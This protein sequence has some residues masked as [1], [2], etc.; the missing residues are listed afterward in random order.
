MATTDLI[1]AW[2]QA[3]TSVSVQ[4]GLLIVGVLA[5]QTCCRLSARVRCWLWCLVL[6]RL[7]VPAPIE[8]P[9]GLLASSKAMAA[10]L[11]GASTLATDATGAASPMVAPAAVDSSPDSAASR[12]ARGGEKS[13][14]D[15]TSLQA[16]AWIA[17]LLWVA[18]VLVLGA[19]RCRQQVVLGRWLA[20]CRRPTPKL[21]TW[22]DSLRFELGIQDRIR[23]RVAP[24][25]A[26]DSDCPQGP[27]L[28]GWRL[29]TIVL[30][31]ALA[32]GWS[33]SRL[34]PVI[35]HELLHARRKDP[36]WNVLLAWIET[37]YFFHPLVWLAAAR[38]RIEREY[39]CDD[40]VVARRDSLLVPYV[41]T[42]V[43]LAVRGSDSLA[44][45][46]LS[47]TRRSQLL[48]RVRRLLAPE[49]PPAGART[50]ISLGMLIVAAVLLLAADRPQPE[51]GTVVRGTV[52]QATVARDTVAVTHQAAVEGAGAFR[53]LGDDEA[54]AELVA[55]AQ[56]CDPETRL[57]R[58]E[59][60]ADVTMRRPDLPPEL[61]FYLVVFSP[62]EEPDLYRRLRSIWRRHLEAE[63]VAMTVL[64]N[65]AEFFA[66]REPAE[67]IAIY[68]RIDSRAP[69]EVETA[70]RLGELYM[71]RS[72]QEDGAMDLRHRA[73]DAFGAAVARGGDNAERLAALARA[74]RSTARQGALT[75]AAGF[76]DR[77][78]TLANHVPPG[79][80]RG[81]AVHGA[82]TILGH[83][84]LTQQ[85]VDGAID[86]LL[87][88]A[89]IADSAVVAASGPDLTLANALLARGHRS[90]VM[91]YLERCRRLWPRGEK[92]LDSW[93]EAI[94]Q[95]R[96]MRLERPAAVETGI[97]TADLT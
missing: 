76:A 47:L 55:L 71:R 30:P 42:L 96:D 97:A 51:I 7:A 16:G 90:E 57:R 48:P 54:L 1:A 43:G 25:G 66:L 50:R 10:G 19:I 82:H 64:H 91:V 45:D 81:T 36:Q 3:M 80:T 69:A 62:D 28:V 6:V 72:S 58:A 40:A 14:S 84:A 24:D 49:P 20:R 9:I 46:G 74:A 21:E 33:P 12:A 15:S 8:S 78:V 92:T 32:E 86:H 31:G 26:L 37:V 44:I 34:E 17:F 79:S 61:A 75:L 95:Q 56:H 29:P 67:A 77:A 11:H 5:A 60:L 88:A 83:Q 35:L 27:V 87:N 2:F 65:A 22:V 18:G 63:A 89:E 23:V 93:I 59:L 68:R 4:A 94:A 39:A 70:V 85:D 13:R 73:V 41:R 38:I 52:A 53:A